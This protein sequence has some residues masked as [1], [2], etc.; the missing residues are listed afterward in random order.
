MQID[1]LYNLITALHK[2]ESAAKREI[3]KERIEPDI[4]REM[5]LPKRSLL[6][7]GPKK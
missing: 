5:Q 4:R 1:D 6:D 7:P 2:A 3:A